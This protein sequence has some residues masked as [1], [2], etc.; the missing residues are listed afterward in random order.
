MQKPKS[1]NKKILFAVKN[2]LKLGQKRYGNDMTDLDPRDWLGEAT[3]EA[4]D[5]IVY[6]TAQH[7]RMLESREYYFAKMYQVEKLMKEIA[8]DEKSKYRNKAKVWN[9]TFTTTK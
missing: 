3:E 8:N 4:L 7:F 1:L 5:Q 2:R 6:L 9:S